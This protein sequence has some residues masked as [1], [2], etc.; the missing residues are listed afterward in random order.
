MVREAIQGQDLPIDIFNVSDGV[1]ALE[2]LFPGEQD[3]VSPLPQ[4]VLLDLNIPKVDGF[5]VLRRIRASERYVSLPVI[6]FTS[7]DSPSD[8]REAAKQANGY[9]RK[10]A[11]YSEFLKLGS[12]LRN[13]LVA[14]KLL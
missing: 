11:E 6:I 8:R 14:R 1:Q 12:F 9:F 5:E 2:F 13:F 4:I 3:D 10:P 7:S